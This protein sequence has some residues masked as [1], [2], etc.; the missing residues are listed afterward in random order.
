MTNRGVT[1]LTIPRTVARPRLPGHASVL[2]PLAAV[3]LGVAAGYGMTMSPTLVKLLLLLPAV[4]FTLTVSTEKL[5][6]AWLFFAPFVQGAGAGDHPG[7]SFYVVLFLAPPLVVLARLALGELTLRGFS[8]TDALPAL[9]VALVLVSTYVLDSEFTGGSASLR[10][11]YTSVGISIFAYYFIAFGRTSERL[12][13]AIVGVVVWSGILLAVF[14]LIE[15]ATG[16]NIWNNINGGPGTG[17]VRRVV[18]TFSSPG[19]LGTY[20]GTGVVFSIAVLGWNGPRSLKKPAVLLIALSI[21]ALY[22]T[23]TRGPILGVAVVGTLMALIA[24]RARWPS[25]LVFVTVALA[26]FATWGDISSSPIYKDRLGVTSTADIRLTVQHVGFELFRERP[27]FGWGYDTF[28]R[29]KLTIPTRDPILNTTTSHNSF[30][31]VLVEL[32]VVGLVLLVLPWI[33]IGGQAIA[34]ARRHRV[35]IWLIAGAVGAVAAYVIGALTYDTRFF[36]LIIAVPWVALGLARRLL[37][38]RTVGDGTR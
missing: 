19:A 3:G 22:F 6:L 13:T 27:V 8:W 26:L 37:V 29:V 35:D 14:A 10:A 5:F 15:A 24:N 32:G 4:V 36:S 33:V 23:Y 38:P 28:D 31:T 7:H 18:A 2:L 25:A 34:A 20:L 1:A 12:P 21:P 16:W 30:L 17:D 9:Y 11:I